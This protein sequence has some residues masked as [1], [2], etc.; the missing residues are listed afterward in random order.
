[1]ACEELLNLLTRYHIDTTI[2]HDKLMQCRGLDRISYD[3]LKILHSVWDALAIDTLFSFSDSHSFCVFVI[4]NAKLRIIFRA[5]KFWGKNF[6][7]ES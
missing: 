6:G 5:S 2:N 3:V 1:M 4:P 7:T